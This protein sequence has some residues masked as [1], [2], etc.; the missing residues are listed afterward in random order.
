MSFPVINK[1]LEKLHKKL[2]G[3]EDN[4]F[5]AFR[6]QP[7]S[8]CKLDCSAARSFDNA[9][10]GSKVVLKDN[11]IR[12]IN[13][14]R[15]KGFGF[16]NEKQRRLEDLEVLAD[17]RH[18][19]APACLIDFTSDFLIALWFACE[20]PKGTEEY[21]K[22]EL[23]KDGKIFILNCYDT[24]KF[25]VASSESIKKPI[26]Y[27]FDDQFSRLWYWVPERLNQRLMDQDAIFIFGKPEIK[28][29]EYEYIVVEGKDKKAISVELEKFFDYSK[30]TLFSDRYALGD[31]YKDFG[32]HE[33]LPE[34]CLEEAVY[35]IQTE[36]FNKAKGLL[37]KITKRRDLLD[38]NKS[39]YLEACFQNAYSEMEE[40]KEKSKGNASLAGE[41]FRA[42]ISLHD[43]KDAED[44]GKDY[45]KHLKLCIKHGYKK[46]KIR[47]MAEEFA[48]NFTPTPDEV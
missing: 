1:Y 16:S 34:V 20:E 43:N 26:K 48:H 32:K 28:D 2:E 6:G 46:Q 23:K 11:Q 18:Y 22:K 39:L 24:Q 41:H 15:L 30:K 8:G 25:L 3:E 35:Y 27:F 4:F 17:L 44:T 37:D 42:I 19:G 38:T 45:I 14:V 47:D 10:R 12:L 36:N 7:D 21:P 29:G 33:K 31:V 40:A 13:D 9:D 5:Y